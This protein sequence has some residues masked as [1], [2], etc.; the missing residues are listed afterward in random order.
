[1]LTRAKACK[2]RALGINFKG[3]VGSSLGLLIFYCFLIVRLI[4]FFSALDNKNNWVGPIYHLIKVS[5]PTVRY[6]QSSTPLKVFHKAYYYMDTFH[7]ITK[8][9]SKKQKV[10]SR[11]LDL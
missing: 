10:I 7:Q 1:M 8:F 11:K 6:P 3:I 2:A 9:I 4:L 5:Y